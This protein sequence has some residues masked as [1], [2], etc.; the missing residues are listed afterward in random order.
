MLTVAHIFPPFNSERQQIRG[1][2]GWPPLVGR[3]TRFMI[4]NFFSSSF[5]WKHNLCKC[6]S[7]PFPVSCLRNAKPHPFAKSCDFSSSMYFF[8]FFFSF[9]FANF[10]GIAFAM[11]S[12]FAPRPLRRS[13]ETARPIDEIPSK[14]PAW[15]G[16]YKMCF[17]GF[18]MC[19]SYFGKVPGQHS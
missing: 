19:F 10:S 17:A 3:R 1:Q 14:F 4:S 9:N 11:F 6:R 15:L 18:M 8:S 7:E 2:Q 16:T 5:T 13:C 12:T